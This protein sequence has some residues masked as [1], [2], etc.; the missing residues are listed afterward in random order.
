MDISPRI[1]KLLPILLA[2]FVVGFVVVIVYFRTQNVSEDDVSSGDTFTTVQYLPLG[3]SY[4]I[5]EGL[6]TSDNWPSQLTAKLQQSNV[7]IEIVANPAVTGYTT[8]DLILNELPLLEQNRVDFVT[9]QIGVNDWVQKININEF[10]ANLIN[11]VD[12]VQTQVTNPDNVVLVTIPDFSVTPEGLKYGGKITVAKGITEF[13]NVIKQVASD[14]DLQ[15]VDVFLLSQRMGIDSTLVGTDK[16]HPS[17]K[18]YA[19]WV[20][21]IFPVTLNL[22]KR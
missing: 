13:N 16:L 8:A 15:V 21:E 4:T 19:R 9:I 7:P 3:D 11:I 1:A 20:E 5:G 12:R 14:R 10:R 22:L 18:E 6:P 17:A 2:V